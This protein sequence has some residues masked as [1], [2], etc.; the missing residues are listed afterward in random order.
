M[1][2]DQTQWMLTKEAKLTLDSLSSSVRVSLSQLIMD[3]RQRKP[4]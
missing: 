4:L 3:E 1:I 2:K